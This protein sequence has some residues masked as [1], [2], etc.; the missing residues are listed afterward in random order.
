MGVHC[1]ELSVVTLQYDEEEAR[2]LIE[3]GHSV[4]VSGPRH[5][6]VSMSSHPAVTSRLIDHPDSPTPTTFLYFK[7]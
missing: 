5:W 6:D 3:F 2:D 7:L 1:T 4:M